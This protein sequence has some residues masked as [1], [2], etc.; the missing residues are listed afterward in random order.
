MS[1]TDFWPAW[2]FYTF[3]SFVPAILSHTTVSWSCQTPNVS[4]GILGWCS[5][6]LLGS[7]KHE[8]NINGDVFDKLGIPITKVVVYCQLNWTV[9]EHERKNFDL[10]AVFCL[11]PQW[12]DQK[13]FCVRVH[14]CNS[15][16]PCIYMY[17]FISLSAYST[18]YQYYFVNFIFTIS[19]SFP[20]L[21]EMHVSTWPFSLVQFIGL[22][23]G[24]GVVF[25]FHFRTCV[26]HC[27]MPLFFLLF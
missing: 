3:C 17:Y 12:I 23:L 16:K 15:Q 19:I 2:I 22:I 5:F 27:L 20:L 7:T 10:P 26:W 18:T 13:V 9:T 25:H 11:P 14:V 8:G 24:K 4:F 6:F 21:R 1:L